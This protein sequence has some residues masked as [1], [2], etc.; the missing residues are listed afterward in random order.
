MIEINDVRKNSKLQID[1]QPYTV[2]D[3]E[4]V[5]PGKGSSFTR[6]RIRNLI[7]GQQFER[8]FKSGERFEEPNLDH[9]EMQYLYSEGEMLYFM[10]NTNYEQIAIQKN[11]LGDQVAFLK[12]N[13]GVGVLFYEDRP[14]N[15][16]LPVFVEMAIEYCEPGFKGNTAT[17][18]SKPARLV[19]GH[20]VSVPLHLKEGD[21]L[22]IDTRTGEYVEKVNK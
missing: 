14:I 12:E 13:I 4:H 6:C 9:R 3:F 2:I 1:G 16:E 8:T 17:G 21:I 7:T 15:V 19:G 20:T 5:K 18:A 11:L 10:D 22:K